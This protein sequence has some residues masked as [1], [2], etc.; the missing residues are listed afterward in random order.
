V[1]R[2]VRIKVFHCRPR[3]FSLTKSEG[4]HGPACRVIRLSWPGILS[5]KRL[6]DRAPAPLHFDRRRQNFSG[7]GDALRLRART[8]CRSYGQLHGSRGLCHPSDNF[9][10]ILAGAE[11][12]GTSGEDFMLALAALYEVQCRFT[13]AV[14]V[15]PKGFNHSTRLAMSMAA[16]TGRTSGSPRQNRI[17]DCDGGPRR[18]VGNYRTFGPN[19]MQRSGLAGAEAMKQLDD[20]IGNTL[21]SVCGNSAFARANSA[22][23]I[24]IIAG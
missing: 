17:G 12:A 11:K 1:G 15:M 20:G 5:D 3:F 7:S 16:S 19:S 13:G 9:G 4:Y 6:C 23:R 10:A 18:R 14:S 2:A 22:L 8:L 24:N 21:V